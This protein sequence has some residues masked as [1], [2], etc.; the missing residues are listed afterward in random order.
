M[1]RRFFGKPKKQAESPDP[2]P[3]EMPIGMKKPESLQQMMIRMIHDADFQRRMREQGVETIDEADDF[4]LEEDEDRTPRTP[5]ELEFDQETNRE[6]LPAEK[7]MIDE[8]RAAF[9]KHVKEK[10]KRAAIAKQKDQ[11]QVATATQPEP[12]QPVNPEGAGR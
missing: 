2:R 1:L 6:Y 5:Y 11:K 12:S 8:A 10:R 4:E 3:I 9:D 7:A